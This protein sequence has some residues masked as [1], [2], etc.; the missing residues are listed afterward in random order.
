MDEKKTPVS[1]KIQNLT[2]AVENLKIAI[3]QVERFLV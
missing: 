1:G 2:Q 3:H